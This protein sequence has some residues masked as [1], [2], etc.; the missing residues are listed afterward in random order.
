[1]LNCADAAIQ[2]HTSRLLCHCLIP[3]ITI[4][5]LTTGVLASAATAHPARTQVADTKTATSNWIEL[6][7]G[8]KLASA[9]LVQGPEAAVSTAEFDA[10]HWHPVRHMP[11]TVLQIL[12][13]DGAYKDLYFGMN[14]VSAG[15]LWKKDWWYRTTFTA[16]PGRQVYSLSF[17]G[18][19]YRADIWV[20][21]QEV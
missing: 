19:N 7:D 1:M 18:I 11:A 21:G 4:T 3:V 13:D 14:L 16:P 17:K 9:D 15:N 12:E 8:W 5:L 10:S 2:N 20:N 6:A